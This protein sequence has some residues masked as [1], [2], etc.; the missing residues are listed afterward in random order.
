MATAKTNEK[1][2][3]DLVSAS[4]GEDVLKGSK[5]FKN[6]SADVSISVDETIEIGGKKI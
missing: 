3:R 1:K 4:F 6:P 5:T 2:F